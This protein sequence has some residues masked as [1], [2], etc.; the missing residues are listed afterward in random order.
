MEKK[1]SGKMHSKLEN[2]CYLWGEALWGEDKLAALCTSAVWGI[3]TVSCFILVS[4]IKQ[5]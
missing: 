1:I 4:R 5:D 3:F 2:C